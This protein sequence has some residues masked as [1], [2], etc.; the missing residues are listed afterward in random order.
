MMRKRLFILAFFAL[1]AICGLIVW[2]LVSNPVAVRRSLLNERLSITAPPD[3]TAAKQDDYATLENAIGAKP[4]LWKP[5]I[6][7]P[8]QQTP[9]PDLEK[10]LGEVAI[11]SGQIGSGNSVRIKILTSK[12]D[13][14]GQWVT[15]GDVVNGLTVQEITETEVVFSLV[16][17]DKEYTTTLPRRRR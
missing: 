14:R 10:L 15:K 4:A 11:G 1:A 5:L 17:G 13:R 16:Q 12:A 2:G 7:R 3:E 8:Q 6:V 9:P